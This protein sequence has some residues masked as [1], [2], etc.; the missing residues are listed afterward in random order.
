M[1]PTRRNFVALGSTAPSAALTSSMRVTGVAMP[2]PTVPDMDPDASNTIMASSL[3]GGT[4]GSLAWPVASP[5]AMAAAPSDRETLNKTTLHQPL[6]PSGLR[7]RAERRG[8]LGQRRLLRLAHLH[9][10]EAEKA[11]LL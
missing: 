3:Q 6:P 9:A 4:S 5:I 8:D 11:A 7:A 2:R 10:A 1:S